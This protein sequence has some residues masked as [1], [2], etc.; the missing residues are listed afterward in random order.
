MTKNQLSFFAT[1]VDLGSLLRAIESGRRLQFVMAGL[2]DSP[3]IAPKQSLLNIP[4]LGAVGSGDPNHE[5]K[6][7]IADSGQPLEGRTVPQRRGGIKYAIDQRENSK[8][9]VFQPGG[10]LR[11]GCLIAGQFGTVS[12]EARSLELFNLFEMETRRQFTRIKSDYVGTEAAELLDAGWR[13]TGNATSPAIYDLKR[14]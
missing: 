2:F 8:T 13:L 10:T 3:E 7:L 4:N 11:E 12:N 5:P 9:I 1:K 14:D 6:Y